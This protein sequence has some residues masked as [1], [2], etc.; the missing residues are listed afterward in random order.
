VQEIR[1]GYVY[2]TSFHCH[3]FHVQ[4]ENSFSLDITTVILSWVITT[5]FHPEI[6]Y[7]VELPASFSPGIF[8]SDLSSD[9]Q[10]T[11]DVE[12]FRRR[13][14]YRPTRSKNSSIL[15][16]RKTVCVTT[17]ISDARDEISACVTIIE[18]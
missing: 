14:L 10:V 8:N 7:G 13:I 12:T 2:N 5:S 18:K 15:L 9:P 4:Y 16:R 6:F 11:D 17:K 1:L 3:M